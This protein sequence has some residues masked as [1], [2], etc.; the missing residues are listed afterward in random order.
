MANRTKFTPKKKKLFLE[1]LSLSANVTTSAHYCGIDRRTAY[2]HRAVDPEFAVQWDDAVDEAID[3]YEAVVNQRAF[4]GVDEPI[5]QQGELVGYA[6]KCSDTL[7]IFML[8]AY[9]PEKFR[10]RFDMTSGG[11]RLKNQSVIVLPQKEEG[12]DE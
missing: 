10:E 7:A 1:Q 12:A 9:R 4:E 6:R 8:K 2:D 5:Y 11:K 3:K